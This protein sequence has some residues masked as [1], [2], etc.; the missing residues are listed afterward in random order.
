LPTCAV[1]ADAWEYD[2]ADWIPVVTAAAPQPRSGCALAYDW[3][4]SRTVLYGGFDAVVGF[5]DTWEYDGST[6][7]RSPTAHSPSGGSP[8]LAYDLARARTVLC[9]GTQN[10]F[11]PAETREYDRTR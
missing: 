7:S 9:V 2:G 4:R 11:P 10:S 1:Q 6:W 8:A 3:I 5:T